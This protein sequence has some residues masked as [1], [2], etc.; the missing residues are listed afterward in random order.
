M[1]IHDWTRAQAGDFH[2]FHQTWIPFLAAALN[3]GGLPPGF[4]ALVTL[5]FGE[6]SGH[7]GGVA[8]ASPTFALS[9]C[10]PPFRGQRGGFDPVGLHYKISQV[11]AVAS[12]S[13]PSRMR[14][15][16]CGGRSSFNFSRINFC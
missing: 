13:R 16:G 7:S 2:H 12:S 4:M 3:G 14:G 9:R 1:P 15:G 6:P 11:G 8:I 5:Q 10:K